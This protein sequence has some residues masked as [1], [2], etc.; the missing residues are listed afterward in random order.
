MRWPRVQLVLWQAQETFPA[1]A[2]RDRDV[3]KVFEHMLASLPG[4]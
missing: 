1:H 3:H 2:P 4:R